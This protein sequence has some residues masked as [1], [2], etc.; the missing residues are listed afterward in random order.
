MSR[1]PALTLPEELLLLAF[2]PS[3]GR[4]RVRRRHLGYG[5]AAAALADLEALR[6]VAEDRGR[7]VPLAPPP[8]GE[9]LLDG[10]LGLF[11][12]GRPVRTTR[13][14]RRRSGAVAELCA[15]AL[16]ARGLVTVE[17]RRALGLFPATRRRP[18]TPEVAQA[19]A[20]G[21]RGAAKLGFPKPRSR[22]LAALAQA[23]HLARGLA[24]PGAGGREIRRTMRGL[25]RELWP[26]R[27][28]T[29]L[30][31]SEAADGAG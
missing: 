6:C 3:S 22:M 27:A 7:V 13:W 9:P 8:T 16:A 20:A 23:I 29:R 18:A 17:R 31:R 15:D 11:R 4:P 1:L 10:V 21:F 25:A 2:D 28:V 19:A 26:A 30:I 5:L 24:P 14:I 12:D